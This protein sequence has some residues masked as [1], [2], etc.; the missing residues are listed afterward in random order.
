[1]KI[2]MQRAQVAPVLQGT[3]EI[4]SR[5]EEHT[6]CVLC[7]TKE[8]PNFIVEFRGKQALS[9]TITTT[10]L[11]G[12]KPRCG[13]RIWARLGRSARLAFPPPSRHRPSVRARGLRG[14]ASRLLLPDPPFPHRPPPPPLPRSLLFARRSGRAAG[15]A[16]A[17][18]RPRARRPERRGAR[19][20]RTARP[21][22]RRRRRRQRGGPGG[23]GGGGISSIGGGTGGEAPPPHTHTPTPAAGM[24]LTR[25]R[26]RRRRRRYDDSSSSYSSRRRRRAE[27]RSSEL[28]PRRPGLTAAKANPGQG[29]L[30]KGFGDTSDYYEGQKA[31]HSKSSGGMAF[32]DL[33]GGGV[34]TL[35]R[36][37]AGRRAGSPGLQSGAHLGWRFVSGG[38]LMLGSEDVADPGLPERNR[39]FWARE[40]ECG[41]AAVSSCPEEPGGSRVAPTLGA[42]ATG[43]SPCG[44][45]HLEPGAQRLLGIAWGN[46]Q[47]RQAGLPGAISK[48]DR[49][50]IPSGGRMCGFG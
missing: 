19:A 50:A 48:D 34:L 13:G 38:D 26:R 18:V 14:F 17:A 21:R 39:V 8:F 30:L 24:R 41:E 45:P 10:P 20:G 9:T 43:L 3:N 44:Q 22:R 2:H 16:A 25:P 32:I 31:F 6:F 36:A 33:G 37:V 42:G 46:L 4:R 49:R 35:Q 15:A 40:C 12:A 27:Q 11:S 5:V 23:G 47:G 29:K 1:M 7:L 28:R